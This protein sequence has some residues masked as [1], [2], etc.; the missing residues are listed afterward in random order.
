MSQTFAKISNVTDLSQLS[1]SASGGPINDDNLRVLVH[2]R[3][4]VIKDG[5]PK[6][7]FLGLVGE[8][9]GP[10]VIWVSEGLADNAAFLLVKEW[11]NIRKTDQR[12]DK[13][14]NSKEH[15]L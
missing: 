9:G 12:W 8:W 7:V 5:S 13:I 11:W 2:P 6:V 10:L 15:L 4:G 1:F 3:S 14:L